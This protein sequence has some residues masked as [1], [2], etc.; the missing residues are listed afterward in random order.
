MYG[1][2]LNLSPT[3]FSAAPSLAN[4][5]TC[6][7]D[8]SSK[9]PLTLLQCTLSSASRDLLLANTFI[10]FRLSLRVGTNGDAVQDSIR[11]Y[12]GDSAFPPTLT[13]TS[14]ATGD[15]ND[16]APFFMRS[17]FS[18]AIPNAGSLSNASITVLAAS[19]SA[20]PVS[21]AGIALGSIGAVSLVAA[22]ALFGSRM[23][24]KKAVKKG[25]KVHS[26]EHVQAKDGAFSPV[27]VKATG[28][29]ASDLP[30]GALKSAGKQDT[31][32]SMKEL[33]TMLN[34][35]DSESLM[36]VNEARDEQ[37]F[38]S[39]ALPV[40]AA[41]ATRQSSSG[42]SDKVNPQID[43]TISALADSRHE[44][45]DNMSTDDDAVPFSTAFSKM[46]KS[47]Q[48]AHGTLADDSQTDDA[49]TGSALDAVIASD[50][51]KSKHKS[52]KRHHRS[53]GKTAEGTQ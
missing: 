46:I 36:D 3:D 45:H 18:N 37:S 51:K 9:P 31:L 40:V 52:S 4:A 13:V 29:P 47:P 35:E 30:K 5:G 28:K 15:S 24:V 53:S 14:G 11:F 16:T 44:D 48:A 20:G 49:A 50:K 10:Q 41:V 26:A 23:F 17:D 12:A 39:S 19:S 38:D 6:A 1:A 22:V 32:Q 43:A 7:L 2:S 33:S 25:A 42:H 34:R 21:K 27:H 8:A